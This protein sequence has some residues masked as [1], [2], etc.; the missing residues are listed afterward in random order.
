MLAS[1]FSSIAVGDDF[2]L[3]DGRLIKMLSFSS[4]VSS[5]SSSEVYDFFPNRGVE[6][7]TMGV[8][9][10]FV[11]RVGVRGSFFGDENLDPEEVLRDG[12]DGDGGFWDILSFLAAAEGLLGDEVF[13][14]MTNYVH[15]GSICTRYGA[16]IEDKKLPTDTFGGRTILEPNLNLI[17]LYI[18]TYY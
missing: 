8:F 7:V 10:V 13:T 16:C 5:T 17:L 4:L 14:I 2:F 9:G 11:L 18:L 1:Y 6:G 3:G 15:F 12:E